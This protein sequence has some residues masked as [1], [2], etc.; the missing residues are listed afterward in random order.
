MSHLKTI[1]FNLFALF[2]PILVT[3]QDYKRC[4]P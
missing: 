1:K 2:V 3:N 4:V